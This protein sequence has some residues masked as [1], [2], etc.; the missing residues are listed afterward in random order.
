M[1]KAV[2]KTDIGNIREINQDDFNC[3]VL[4]EDAV[5]AV[6]CDGMGGEKG[7]HIASRTAADIV[8]DSV[9]AAYGSGFGDNSIRGILQTAVSRSI[10]DITPSALVIKCFLGWKR[11]SS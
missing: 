6:V 9:T 7:G 11:A 10:M 3:G 4:G 2:G 1:L 8:T 5:F